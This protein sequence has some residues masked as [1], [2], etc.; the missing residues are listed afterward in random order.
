MAVY[1]DQTFTSGMYTYYIRVDMHDNTR[2]DGGG[3][4]TWLN[5]ISVT[6]Y[7]GTTSTNSTVIDDNIVT[8]VMQYAQVNE[9]EINGAPD[10]AVDNTL[11]N[12]LGYTRH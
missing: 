11:V 2:D 1:Y 9:D 4:F 5:T 8:L 10:P 12:D 7:D 3:K 6:N